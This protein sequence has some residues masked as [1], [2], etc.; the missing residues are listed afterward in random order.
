MVASPYTF[1]N[2]LPTDFEKLVSFFQKELPSHFSTRQWVREWL[3]WPGLTPGKDLFI[4][5]IDN[6]IAGYICVRPELGIGR[7]VLGCRLGSHH[8]RKGLALLLLNCALKRAR[9]LGAV[10]AHVDVM[11]DNLIARKALERDEFKVVREYYQL[12]M[13]MS[14]VDWEEAEK[15]SQGC[16]H[17]MPG[18]EA[19][20][21]DIQN[22]SFAEHWGYNPNTSETIAFLINRDQSSPED[23]VLTCEE[24]NI[25]G[26]CRTEL[27]GNGEG[28]ILMIGT[29]PDYRGKGIGKKSLLAG[30]IYLRSKDVHTV[31]LTVDTA[32]ETAINLY[33]SVG[34]E[35]SNILMTYEKAVDHN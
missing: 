17:L 27:S 28:R 33:K 29:D 7:V 25:I 13:H 35:H 31:Y 16:R 24:D 15:V 3:S 2:Y 21:A 11:A 26:F 19:A 22:R 9:E 23:I 32:N 18:E 4:V 8:R 10:V 6:T 14:K 5:E 34:F 30:L 12:K 1:R 20:L